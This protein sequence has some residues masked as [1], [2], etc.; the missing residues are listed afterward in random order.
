MDRRRFLVTSLAGAIAAPLAAEGQQ[1]VKLPTIGLLGSG[2][3]T[4]QSQWTT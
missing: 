2:T 1:A 4:A 3:A